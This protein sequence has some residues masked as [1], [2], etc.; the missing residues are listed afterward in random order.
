MAIAV[1]VVSAAGVVTGVVT[2]KGSSLTAG[3]FA[4]LNPRKGRD[5]SAWCCFFF[6]PEGVGLCNAAARGRL[7]PRL[8]NP[9]PTG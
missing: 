3:G 8:S 5:R 7:N 2:L 6:D 1:G 4:A 9:T